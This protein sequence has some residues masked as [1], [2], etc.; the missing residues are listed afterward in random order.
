MHAEAKACYNIAKNWY[1]DKLA[2]YKLHA[3]LYFPSTI[4]TFLHR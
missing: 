3:V 2:S 4:H 1:S